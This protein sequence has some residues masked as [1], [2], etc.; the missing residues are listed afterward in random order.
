VPAG[1][2]LDA[3]ATCSRADAAWGKIP[4]K[5]EYTRLLENNDVKQFDDGTEFEY[6]K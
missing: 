2:V 1:G 5:G 4:K 6:D 3:C